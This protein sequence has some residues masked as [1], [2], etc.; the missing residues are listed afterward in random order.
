ME[1]CQR[2]I[3]SA[4][5]I[6]MMRSSSKLRTEAMRLVDE[7]I[8]SDLCPNLR[9]IFT[10]TNLR[11]YL[12]QVDVNLVGTVCVDD[13]E[14]QG[15][16]EDENLRFCGTVAQN[17]QKGKSTSLSFSRSQGQKTAFFGLFGGLRAGIGP[18]STL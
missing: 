17:Q 5:A 9:L 8:E 14:V 4:S 13:A 18:H 1:Q 3:D 16:D 6:E 10:P 15:G 12:P 11:Q 7:Q 2:M